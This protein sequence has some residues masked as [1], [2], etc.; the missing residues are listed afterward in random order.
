LPEHAG[1][2]VILASS[3]RFH[4]NVFHAGNCLDVALDKAYV[5][6]MQAMLLAQLFDE[7][8]SVAKVVSRQ[9]REEMMLDLEL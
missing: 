4:S 2:E 7:S 9:A 8:L 3:A 5:V 1:E 6:V